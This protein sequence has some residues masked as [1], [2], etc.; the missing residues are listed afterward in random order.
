MKNLIKFIEPLKNIGVIEWGGGKQPDGKVLFPFPIYPD[1]VN[2]FEEVF[3]NSDINDYK[4]REKMDKKGWWNVET[5][6]KDIPSMT[7]NEVG[8]CITAIIRKER[9]CDGTIAQFLENGVLVKLLER[10]ED[11]SV[12]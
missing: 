11:L 10:L 5:M 4:Y 8:T 3:Y 2:E 12:R 7:K 9:F 1:V 6:E